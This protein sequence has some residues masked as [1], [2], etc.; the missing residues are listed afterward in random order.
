MK[1]FTFKREATWLLVLTVVVPA[2]GILL[3]IVWPAV[4]RWL[5]AR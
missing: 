2:A 1:T 4:A 5:A 3:A